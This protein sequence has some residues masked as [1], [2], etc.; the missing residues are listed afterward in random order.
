M[1]G[2]TGSP[3]YEVAISYKNERKLF[4]IPVDFS[5][6]DL[7]AAMTKVFNI[8]EGYAVFMYLKK[9]GKLLN[10]LIRL[11]QLVGESSTLKNAIDTDSISS[12]AKWY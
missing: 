9:Y 3:S 4:N 1:F 6:N 2:N 8:D 5:I 10:G 12:A 11:S 7:I